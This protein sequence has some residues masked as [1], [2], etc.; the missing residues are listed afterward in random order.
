MLISK[1]YALVERI[2]L[3][4]FSVLFLASYFFAI[5]KRPKYQKIPEN[6]TDEDFLELL[7]RI[8]HDPN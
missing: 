3:T 6:R 8:Q 7:R 1:D 4:L 5:Y 2:I